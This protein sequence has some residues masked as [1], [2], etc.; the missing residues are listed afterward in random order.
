MKEKFSELA[1]YKKGL[2]ISCFITFFLVIAN[3]IRIDAFLLEPIIVFVNLIVFPFVL[4]LIL[5]YMLSPLVNF[6][7]KKRIPRLV[8]IAVIA[9]L[10]IGLLT[11]SV[12][13]LIPVVERQI[14]HFA[15]SLPKD[16]DKMHDQA[17]RI[18]EDQ[19][20]SSIKEFAS[21]QVN[22]VQ[23]IISKYGSSGTHELL[24]YLSNL[25]DTLETAFLG[26]VITPFMLFYM[27][28][29]DSHLVP[30]IMKLLPIPVRTPAK[31]ILKEIDVKLSRYIRGQA[32][33]AIF[34]FVVLAITFRIIHLEY[35]IT[36]ALLTGI[37][38]FL[39]PSFG[40]MIGM[41]PALLVA[42]FQSWQE[43]I[44]VGIV[45][46]VVQHI[47]SHLLAPIVLGNQLEIH[48]LT[49]LIL[50]IWSSQEAG[51]IGLVLVIPLYACIKVVCTHAFRAYKK[52]SAVYEN[53]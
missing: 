41:V 6:L 53:E 25:A 38:N 13:I 33:V 19:R 42:S 45:Y 49:I 11:L 44:A 35:G 50:L 21:H 23:E 18:L 15:H 12:W 22:R 27:L 8:S 34:V 5:Y 16:I 36:L 29:D 20:F 31:D 24:N 9:I 26:L 47:E 52:K 2:I 51:F 43:L 28:K 39:V 40:A 10:F 1:L 4:S 7:E 48:P 46:Y 17:L 37:T 30:K 32:I 14:Y 3:L